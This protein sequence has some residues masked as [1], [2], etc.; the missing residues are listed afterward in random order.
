MR[1]E[2]RDKSAKE[3]FDLVNS[4][5]KKIGLS[6]ADTLSERLGAKTLN[7]EA[8]GEDLQ[9][10]ILHTFDEEYER[11]RPVY[12]EIKGM[13]I[14]L[15]G[16]NTWQ[17]ERKYSYRSNSYEYRLVINR[18]ENVKIPLANLII[19]FDT[20]EELEAAFIK[21]KDLKIFNYK[22]DIR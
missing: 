7:F 9:N 8:I 2:E 12:V 22:V 5:F 3:A 20:P 17:K 10:Y 21:I 14:P 13:V 18:T 15:S 1:K 19:A 11:G 16:I 4:L 6:V